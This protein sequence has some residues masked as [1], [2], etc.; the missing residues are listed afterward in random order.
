MIPFTQN[1]Q[2]RQVSRYRIQ[3]GGC[4]ESGM[5]NGCLIDRN[6]CFGGNG[7]VLKLDGGNGCKIL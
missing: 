7:N 3:M 6:G 4:V 5:G 1:I 2:E